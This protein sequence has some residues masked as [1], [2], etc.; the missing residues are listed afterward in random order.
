VT[1]PSAPPNPR[2][3]AGHSPAI[4]ARNAAVARAAAQPP[5]SPAVPS[6]IPGFDKLSYEQKRLAQDQAARGGR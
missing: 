1:R 4:A 3:I 2:A 6:G 5:I